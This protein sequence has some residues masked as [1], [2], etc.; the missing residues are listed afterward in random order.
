MSKDGSENPWRQVMET[1]P[2]HDLEIWRLGIRLVGHVY[3]V[4]DNFPDRE[5]FHL[6]DQLRRAAT[7]VPSNIAEGSAR[8][9]DREFAR[10]LY[11]A[12]GSLEEIDTQLELAGELGYLDDL[13]LDELA[14]TFENLSRGLDGL[15]KKLRA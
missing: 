7:G 13:A 3:R 8:D 1:R 12:R 10:Y 4:T 5:R 9:S 15:I 6:Q 14:V 11:M 2:H